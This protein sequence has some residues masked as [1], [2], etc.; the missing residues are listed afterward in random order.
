MYNQMQAQQLPYSTTQPQ[1][2]FGNYQYV[3]NIQFDAYIQPFA[4]VLPEL[5]AAVIAMIQQT[6]AASPQR[7]FLFNQ[8]ARNG[9]MNEDFANLMRNAMLLL[10]YLT[11]NRRLTGQQ[12]DILT[13]ADQIV[14]YASAGNCEKFP[15]LLSYSQNPMGIQ[16][17][18]QEFRNIGSM[19]AA[20]MNP[21]NMGYPGVMQQMTVGGGMSPSHNFQQA[22][23]GL[24]QPGGSLFVKGDRGP[25]G[26]SDIGNIG[27]GR[28]FGS[29]PQEQIQANSVNPIQEAITSQRNADCNQIDLN[30]ANKKWYPVD[31]SMA[32]PAYE[33]SHQKLVVLEREG[34]YIYQVKELGADEMDPAKHNLTPLFNSNSIITDG[35][36]SKPSNAAEMLANAVSDAKAAKQGVDITLDSYSRVRFDKK[37]PIELGYDS[38]WVSGIV[39]QLRRSRSR[40]AEQPINII[41][42]DAK[43]AKAVP[44]DNKEHNDI[45]RHL[46]KLDSVKLIAA[47]R[48]MRD[49][50]DPALMKIIDQRLTDAVNEAIRLNMSIPDLTIDSFV[51]DWEDLVNYIGKKYGELTAAQFISRDDQII[52]SAITMLDDTCAQDVTKGIYETEDGV[53]YPISYFAQNVSFTLLRVFSS[54]LDLDF[55]KNTSAV[56]SKVNTR[57]WY[58]LAE[59]IFKEYGDTCTRHLVRTTDGEVL[60]IRKG[61]LVDD[62][63]MIGLAK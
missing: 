24:N 15:A 63:Y 12:Q 43:I 48:N 47:L 30:V 9:F 36:N 22:T 40:N 4:R 3:P 33:P 62:A 16:N 23:S 14:N 41:Q 53:E 7:M 60:E 20:E 44:V 52:K 6:A 5:S 39:E 28:D 51:D 25:V 19:I 49:K 37:M 32:R 55:V 61:W 45:I 31:G 38:V 42:W 10:S 11:R 21:G 50:F 58:D 18:N 34:R 17:V 54:E 13:V 57:V 2:Q 46:S 59:Q 8:M 35:L 26:N 1:W 29:A 27:F 56:L